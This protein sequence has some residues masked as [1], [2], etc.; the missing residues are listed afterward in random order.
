MAE[1]V[2]IEELKGKAY[3]DAKAKQWAAVI[4]ERTKQAVKGLSFVVS[5]SCTCPFPPTQIHIHTHTVKQRSTYQ[6]T[7]WWCR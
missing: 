5:L 2:L 1:K 6:G 7:K 4:A 3:D